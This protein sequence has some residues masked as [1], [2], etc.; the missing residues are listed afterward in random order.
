MD[1]NRRFARQQNKPIIHGHAQG[2]A[3]GSNVLEWWL[4]YL[5]NT[6][7]TASSSY[8]RYLT[9]WAFSSENFSRSEEEREGLFRLMEAEFK[10]LAFTSL[11]HLFRI[12]ICVIGGEREFG[13][14]PLELRTTIAMLEEST[15]EYNNLVLLLAV[16]YEVEEKSSRALKNF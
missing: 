2:A 6:V 5:P 13:Q 15:H 3:T 11:V 4:K 16:G 1:G 9:C 7:N 12:R 14:L 10:F 8:P